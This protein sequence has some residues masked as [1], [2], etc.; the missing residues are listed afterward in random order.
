M[1]LLWIS[2]TPCKLTWNPKNQPV[3][4][5]AKESSIHF[6]V[7]SEFFIIFSHLLKFYLEPPSK[8][9]TVTEL[10]HPPFSSHFYGRISQQISY[11]H[12]SFWRGVWVCWKWSRQENTTTLWVNKSISHQILGVTLFLEA[13]SGFFPLFK[14]V[15]V[16]RFFQS[17]FL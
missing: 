17:S 9:T 15:F 1:E 11:I 3:V 14:D 13:A 12:P 7:R 10:A 4:Q 16:W 2:L 8:K 5:W 6:G